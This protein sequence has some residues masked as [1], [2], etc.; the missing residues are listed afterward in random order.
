MF[1]I[2]SPEA[3]IAVDHPLRRIKAMADEILAGLTTTFEPGGRPSI[4]PARSRPRRRRQRATHL[5]SPVGS[6]R[7]TAR[8]GQE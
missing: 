8:V 4:P 7:G 1:S 2:V 5:G 3:R 6:L